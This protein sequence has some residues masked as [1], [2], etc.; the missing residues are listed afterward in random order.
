M[1]DRIKEGLRAC[2]ER[3]TLVLFIA[4]ALLVG[5]SEDSTNPPVLQHD[6]PQL[7]ISPGDTSATFT[8]S[9]AG[10]G[11]LTFTLTAGAPWIRLDPAG[12]ST[13]SASEQVQ[14]GIDRDLLDGGPYEAS[15]LIDSNGGGAELPVSLISALTASPHQ[16]AAGTRDTSFVVQLSNIGYG[17]GVDTVRWTAGGEAAWIG[18]DVSE[19]ALMDAP[20]TVA[21]SI[22]RTGLGVGEHRARVWF[23]AGDV[24]R[25]TVEVTM[26]VPNV[27]TVSGHVCFSGTRVPVA[28]ATVS[29]DGHQTQSAADGS[30]SL[31]EVTMGAL[32][33]T[34]EAEG[35]E[36]S[37]LDLQLP[38]DG[39]EM[40]IS[41]IT[42]VHAHSIHG[43]VRNSLGD[44]L[45]QAQV[46][47]LN[48]DGAASELLGV[49]ASDGRFILPS[50]PEGDRELSI[51]HPVYDELIYP[52]EVSADS[53]TLELALRATVLPPPLP[54]TG[55]IL[56]R[57]DCSTMRVLWERRFEDTLAGY[58]VERAP[59]SAGPFV[60][61]S[62]L[63]PPETAF[64]DDSGLDLAIYTYR[65][66]SITID[67]DLSEPSEPRG[68][69]LE[70]WSQLD[71][72]TV[73]SIHK[74]WGH[75]AYY[76][77]DDETMIIYAGIDCAPSGTC[78]A[79]R[80]MWGFDLR[81]YTWEL[82]DPGLGGPDSRSGH[83]MIHHPDT[84]RL[85]V[86]GGFETDRWYLQTWAYDLDTGSWSILENG[87]ASPGR[88]ESHTAVYNPS[89]DTMVLYGGRGDSILNDLWVFH[90]ATNEW[91]LIWE[92]PNHG[93]D[94]PLRRYEHT[95][96][97][98]EA[99]HRMIVHGGVYGAFVDEDFYADTWALDLASLEWERL[100]DCSVIHH[101]H[102][103]NVA[104]GQMVVIGDYADE[105]DGLS[106]TFDLGTEV[107]SRLDDGSESSRPI[108]RTRHSAIH[109]P[110]SMG[111]VVFGGAWIIVGDYLNLNDT[112]TYCPL[113]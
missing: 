99:T 107:W 30:F 109:V 14:V 102:T 45:R 40:T 101:G 104:E 89:G 4:V 67:D 85:I 95:A 51:V 74:R 103:A 83:S 50:V 53:D 49:T 59:T 48:P 92:G 11:T 43:T 13:T 29:L 46:G 9:N 58:Q 27:N 23:D 71:D 32:T 65:V 66:R 98:D 26:D 93:D 105:V 57:V 25:D 100:P 37:S 34:A 38:E 68:I 35:F 22:S 10:G 70:P 21:I 91:E 96:V 63:V 8:V 42:N 28:G 17:A 82:I 87:S 56:V 62:G 2:P 1:I 47:L 15:I 54:E 31:S 97:Y 75:T 19:G 69:V 90:F 86:F 61:I 41:L 39:L 72:G 80:D 73:G 111:L 52:L 60:D 106:W 113:R 12:G 78:A 5:C 20:D 36:P 77:P 16:L 3:G 94:L 18:L 44:P 7:S 64:F 76:S 108:D 24:G 33:L 84:N 112:W 55:P 88:R 79:I 6:P 110:G 81:T